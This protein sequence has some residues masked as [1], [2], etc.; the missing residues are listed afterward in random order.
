MFKTL[1]GR[2]HR[3][4]TNPVKPAYVYNESISAT[5]DNET[6]EQ[7]GG[8]DFSANR[9]PAM[10]GKIKTFF[11]NLTLSQ[12]FMLASLVT[13]LAGLLGIGAWVEQQIETGVIHRTGAATALYVD[14]FVSPYLQELGQSNELYP[15]HFEGL[16]KLLSD[17]PMGQRIVAFK[18]W[19]TRGKL[20]YTTDQSVV[21]KTYPMHEGLLSA[22][23]GVVVSSISS[24]DD[25]ENAPLGIRYDR[26]LE[27]YSPVWLSGTNQVIA[28][29]EFYE[30]TDELDQEIN[31]M[32]VRTWLVVGLAILFIYLL[33]SGFVQRA[34]DTITQQQSELARKV[35]QL[36]LLLAQ[37]RVLN[38]RVRRAAASVALLNESY[39]RRVGSE[40]HDG[41]AQELGLSLLKL[42]AA[43]GHLEALPP[44]VNG[45]DLLAQLNEIEGSLQNAFKE[46]RGIASGLSLPQLAELSLPETVVRATRA[47]E[48][49][50]STQVALELGDI[51]EQISPP[52]KIT[53]YRL[54]QEA[55]NNAFRH[56][57]G[58]GQ[59]VCVDTEAGQL[60][61]KISDQGPGF[62]TEQVDAWDE[63]LGITGMHERVESLGGQ[64][65]IHSRLGQGT[66]VIARLPFQAAGE[67]LE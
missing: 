6:D 1:V 59:S 32:K 20:L 54:I 48:R 45:A 23:L 51:P 62:V 36:T 55:L 24:L 42:D 25:E 28:V 49:R 35:D 44:Q 41:P 57:N 39:L 43:I 67:E 2:K 10:L 63:H 13:L 64:F 53:V 46:M 27:T 3:L 31:T 60:V 58:A 11:A 30:K 50:S 15:T 16:E 17:T 38:G 12:R 7:A 56:A 21:G 37:N 22:R 65:E 5:D 29:A 18:V 33:L 4:W 34:S 9:K 52:V 14:S 66:E 61:V 47:H 26:L 8:N 40:L 19:D